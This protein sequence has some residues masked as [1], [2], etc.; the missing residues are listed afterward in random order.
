[1]ELHRVTKKQNVIYKDAD[2]VKHKFIAENGVLCSHCD[3]HT[4]VY[5]AIGLAATTSA[6][7][8]LP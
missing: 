6:S 4:M 3:L 1:M 7:W 5:R 2:G 8:S